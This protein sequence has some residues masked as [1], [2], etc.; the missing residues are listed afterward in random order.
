MRKIG[1]DSRIV[2]IPGIVLVFFLLIAHNPFSKAQLYNPCETYSGKELSIQQFQSLL[3]AIANGQCDSTPANVKLSFSLTKEDIKEISEIIGFPKKPELILYREAK[4][5]GA[6]A[7]IIQGNSDEYP[8][9]QWD[10][11]M[12]W[13]EGQPTPDVLI[14]VT[15]QGC[16]IYDSDCDATCSYVDGMCDPNCYLN[17]TK[18]NVVCDLDCVDVNKNEKIDPDDMDGI[19]DLD[20]YNNVSDPNRAYDPDCVNTN[21]RRLD[22]VCDPDSSGVVD[23]VCD[24]DCA[25]P[26]D[27]HL[28]DPDCDGV[29]DEGNPDGRKDGDCY[30]CD[31]E[32]NNFC[33]PVCTSEDSD[34]DCPNGFVDWNVLT[35]CCG[36]GICG[37]GEDCSSCPEDCPPDSSCE[38]LGK[39]C[40][41][42]APDKDGY[43]CTPSKNLLEEEECY[44]ENQCNETL[45]CTVGHC[46]PLGKFWN[47]TDCG[48]P[49]GD[50]LVI[51]VSDVVRKYS[52]LFD[53]YRN[54]LIADGYSSQIIQLDVDDDVKRCESSLTGV[55]VPV[56][57]SDAQKIIRQCIVKNDAKYI[58]IVG[59]HGYIH[60]KYRPYDYT[61]YTDDHYADINGDGIPDIPIGRLPDG[62]NHG[63]DVIEKALKTAIRLHQAHGWSRGGTDYTWMIMPPSPTIHSLECNQNAINKDSITTCDSNP[64]CHFAPPHVSPPL[65]WTSRTDLVYICAHGNGAGTQT[66]RTHGDYRL[67]GTSLTIGQRDFTDT[68]FIY[69]PCWGGRIHNVNLAQSSVLQ[70]LNRGAAAVFGG[71]QPQSYF[72]INSACTWSLDRSTGTSFLAYTAKNINKGTYDTIGDAW[73]AAKLLITDIVQ[74]E[75]NE[76]YGDPSIRIK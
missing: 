7:L 9:K 35:E 69:N 59:G 10:E 28:C 36:N 22:D 66:L 25:E 55:S 67:M 1:F 65:G 6:G 32:C 18:E 68:I 62:V 37:S 5:L 63:D 13:R 47:G 57:S 3:M 21:K 64:N 53:D 54:A 20:C 74:R 16:D 76:L 48:E 45:S 4:P 50:V 56:S 73:L 12:I 2:L 72:P 58:V 75:H 11:V 38:D 8:L 23:D 39:I 70:A 29:V 30:E 33:S 27:I 49:K 44:C 19:C 42:L 51:T 31:Y 34:P 41:P 14:N 52:G 61:Y 43:G 26:S 60:Q 17:Q 24:P 15:L 71:T 46:C 40:C